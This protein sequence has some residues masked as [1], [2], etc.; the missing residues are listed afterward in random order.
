MPSCW[1]TSQA[2]ASLPTAWFRGRLRFHA[3]PLG[4]ADP[5]A[6]AL[7]HATHRPLG[8]TKGGKRVMRGEIRRSKVK[9]IE[10]ERE[11]VRETGKRKRKIKREQASKNS[12]GGDLLVNCNLGA[13][14]TGPTILLI[15]WRCRT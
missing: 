4:L 10:R 1:R 12:R 5:T 15:D 11:R 6:E 13:A 7:R 8:E 9:E 2:F 14:S 3:Q